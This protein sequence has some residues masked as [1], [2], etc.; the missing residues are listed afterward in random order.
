M[1]DTVK[2]TFDIDRAVFEQFRAIAKR[3]GRKM[4]WYVN[5]AVR[6]LVEQQAGQIPQALSDQKP[7]SK[8]RGHRAKTKS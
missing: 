2:A 6:E 1:G 3:E 7:S 4:T 5:K 8:S